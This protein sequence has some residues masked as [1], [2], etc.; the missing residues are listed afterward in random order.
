LAPPQLPSGVTFPMTADGEA[1][2]AL[3][4][5]TEDGLTLEAFETLA[6]AELGLTLEA[7]EML[8]AAELGFTEETLL[9]EETAD[10]ETDEEDGLIEEALEMLDATLDGLADEEILDEALALAVA[11][12]GTEEALEELALDELAI[13]EELFFELVAA[14]VLEGLMEEAAPPTFWTYAFVGSS[15]RHSATVTDFLPMEAK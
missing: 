13:T 5:F 3:E 11:E 1:A 9:T 4:G 8:A 7:F 10:L 2:A 15:P 6:T 12:A 14:A